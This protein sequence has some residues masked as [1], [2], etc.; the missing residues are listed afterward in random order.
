MLPFAPIDEDGNIRR[1]DK[2]RIAQGHR[3]VRLD[4]WPNSLLDE[5]LGGEVAETF[6]AGG[7]QHGFVKI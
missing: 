3:L 4:Y 1:E 5:P 7:Y 6:E 2:G